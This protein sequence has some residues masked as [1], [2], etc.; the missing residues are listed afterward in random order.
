[1]KRSRTIE[2]S[3]IDCRLCSALPQCLVVTWLSRCELT[4]FA[5]QGLLRNLEL[6]ENNNA[7]L[8]SEIKQLKAE[9]AELIERL[10]ATTRQKNAL[11]DELVALRRE[12][13]RHVETVN[14]I[15]SEKES[16]TKSCAELVV[17]LTSAEKESRQHSEVS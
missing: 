16:L 13:E 3:V 9:R 15:N 17:Q 7:V 5:C 8:E 14:R 6:T 10:N 1:M 12:T 4:L 2:I 11:A